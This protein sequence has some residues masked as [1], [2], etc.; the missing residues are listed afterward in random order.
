M[1]TRRYLHAALASLLGLLLAV[2]ALGASA[3]VADDSLPPTPPPP[4][5]GT[6]PLGSNVAANR[7]MSTGDYF[8][9]PNGSRAQQRAIRSRVLD[10]IKSTNGSYCAPTGR[11]DLLGNPIYE[12][13]HGVIKI[14]TWSFNDWDITDALKAAKAR[15]VSV[16]AVAARGVNQKERYRAWTGGAGAR[17]KLGYYSGSVPSDKLNDNSSWA[18]DCPGACRGGGGTPHSKYFLFDDVGTAHRRNLVMQTS[19]NLT[20]FAFK[21]QWNQ[22][23]VMQDQRV[24]NRFVGIFYESAQ[25][26]RNGY[27]HYVDGAVPGR[28]T[29]DTYFFPNHSGPDPVLTML[30]DEVPSCA[31]GRRIRVVQYALYDTRGIEIAQRLRRLWNDGCNV[32]IIYSISSRNVL[33]ILRAKSGRGPV[34][35]KQSTIKN[36]RGK[37]KKYNH[38][39]W[40][41]VGDR[42]QAGSSNWSDSTF[43]NDEQIQ[44]FSGA[45]AYLAAF[46]KTWRQKSSHNPPSFKTRKGARMIDRMP[47]EPQW[48]KGELKFLTPEG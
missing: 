29:V 38:S 11:T 13:R 48:G 1:T 3:A 7:P 6:A 24:Y 39:K 25:E 27:R 42:V 40:V 46:D 26:I 30:R 34:P 2:T 12:V 9:Y 31:G 14:M 10:T 36:R 35:M 32:R 28:G 23:T 15:G 37:V 41:A 5:D 44:E 8:S 45:S 20:V 33:K 47:A 17:T 43:N 19:M 18:H 4:C 16:Q 21:G 22:A